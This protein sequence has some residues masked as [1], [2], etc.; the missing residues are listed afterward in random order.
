MLPLIRWHQRDRC[1][2]HVRVAESAHATPAPRRVRPAAPRFARAAAAHARAC[3]ARRRPPFLGCAEG[4]VVTISTAFTA[5]EC[6]A[7][8]SVYNGLTNVV[9]EQ[10]GVPS[11]RACTTDNCNGVLNVAVPDKGA[12]PAPP[13]TAVLSQLDQTLLLVALICGIAGA[14][15]SLIIMLSLSLLRRRD[16]AAPTMARRPGAAALGRRPGGAPPQPQY[17]EEGY[18]YGGAQP[19][20]SLATNTR[21]NLLYEHGGPPGGGYPPGGGIPRGGSAGSGGGGNAHGYSAPAGQAPAAYGGRAASYD[22]GNY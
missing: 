8:D 19:Q 13:S 7:F 12:A 20:Q 10:Q 5:A 18:E 15:L 3:V 6:A 17:Q 9:N 1:A 21:R 14:G 4:A 11:V 2:Q 22:D 16:A